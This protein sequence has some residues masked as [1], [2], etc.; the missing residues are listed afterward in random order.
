MTLLDVSRRA[1]RLGHSIHCELVD[2]SDSRNGRADGTLTVA[3]L[4][5]GF[6]AFQ[7][8]ATSDWTFVPQT[9][10]REIPV[11]TV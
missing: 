7:D 9:R 4:I 6:V 5:N 10:A 1:D 2:G 11:M 3:G 8:G